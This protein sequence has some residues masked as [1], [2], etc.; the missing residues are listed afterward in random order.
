VRPVHDMTDEM[1]QELIDLRPHT[2]YVKSVWKGKIQTLDVERVPGAHLVDVGRIAQKNAI[3]EGILKPRSDIEEEIRE[4]QERWRRRGGNE[5]PPPTHTGGNTPPSLPSGSAGSDREPPPTHY[6]PE[7]APEEKP[8]GSRDVSQQGTGAYRP[9]ATEEKSM[10]APLRPSPANAS[11]RPMPSLELESLRFF[12]SGQVMPEKEQ[13]RYST[14]FP[15][16]TACYISFELTMRNRLYR[17]RSEIYSLKMRYFNPDG[18]ILWERQEDRLIKSDN[19]RPSYAMGYG[20][21]QPGRWKVGTYRVE[22]LIDGVKFAE[23][24]FTIE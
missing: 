2:A 15:Q 6:I 1:A 17:Q 24:S 20:W 22:I 21:V 8:A 7:K 16:R 9:H 3:D 14:G 19:E 5:P 4:R 10:R 11:S 13:R 23:G 18:S 12:E